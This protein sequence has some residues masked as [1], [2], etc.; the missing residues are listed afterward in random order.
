MQKISLLLAVTLFAVSC[1]SSSSGN[2]IV[3]VGLQPGYSG[4]SVMNADGTELR[5]L[6]DNHLDMYPAWS[7]DGNQIAFESTRDGDAEIFVMNAD[8]TELRQLTNT[9]N[10]ANASYP[11]WSPDGK[12]IAFDRHHG[13]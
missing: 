4:I 12:Q 3:F 6:T 13:V 10:M 8:G 2:Q 5:Q 7:P 11:A 1:G 9:P